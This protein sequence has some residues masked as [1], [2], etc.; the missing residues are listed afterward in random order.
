VGESSIPPCPPQL[1][2]DRWHREVL[3]TE[4]E[5]ASDNFA[6][7]TRGRFDDLGVLD[8]SRVDGRATV[9]EV[10]VGT[11]NFLSLFS[12]E[13]RRLVGVD[14]TRAM[15][16]KARATWPE[17]E[18]IE[19][20]GAR[21]PLKSA[22]IDLASTAQT[23]HHVWEPLPVLKELRRV[24]GEQGRVLIVDQVATER[25]E[26]AKM[27]NQL[28]V[29]RDPSHAASRPSSALRMLLRAAGLQ[30]VDERIEERRQ[31]LSD[32]MPP[33]E[34]PEDR[35]AKVKDF[36][37][38]HGHLTGMNFE[39]DGNDYIYDRRRIMLLAERA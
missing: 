12:G 22:S 10:G 8:F 26:E 16:D 17:M 4:F 39:A 11:G 33:V 30:I 3:R 6:E 32:W 24:A 35:I 9:L 37:E 21:L 14:L 28:D 34:F 23:L 15:L 25:F 7:R 36:I 29:L 5:R 2:S 19:G 38:R 31:R 1:V 13:A 18:L 27:M 20:D